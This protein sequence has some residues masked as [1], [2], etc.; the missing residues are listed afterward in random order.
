MSMVHETYNGR[1][2]RIFI[3]DA[4]VSHPEGLQAGVFLIEKDGKLKPIWTY[5]ALPDENRD[6][7]MRKAKLK[8][9]EYNQSQ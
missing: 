5:S 3:E 8:I 4:S 6:D 9:K 1:T 2:Y 7:L